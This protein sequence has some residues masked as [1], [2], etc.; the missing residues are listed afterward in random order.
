MLVH[1]GGFFPMAGWPSPVVWGHYPLLPWIGITAVGYG[2]SLVYTWPAARRRRWLI[3][4]SA[5]MLALFFVLR[6]FNVYGDPRPWSP[7]GDVVRSAMAF[8]DVTKYPPS[9]LFAL[10][11]LAPTLFTLGALDGRTF[12]KLPL[13]V[14]VTF[15]R[16]PL[17]FYLLQWPTAHL[18]GILVTAL[19]GKDTSF[20]FMHVLA[21]FQLSKPPVIGGPLWVVYVCWVTGV[22][23]L[24]WP[25][26]WFASLKARRRDWWLSYL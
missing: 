25:C 23:L 17:F 8:F 7:R 6:T 2:L 10:V 1:Q 13:S 24:Y 5:C 22:F 21:L 12:G 3:V 9:L 11:T 20:Y 14:A 19:Q 15:G 26:H 4:T 16:V 18:A